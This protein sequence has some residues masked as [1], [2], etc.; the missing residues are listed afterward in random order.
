M[1]PGVCIVGCGLIG[2]K[3]SQALAGARL[4]SCADVLLDRARVIDSV[5][6]A[7]FTQSARASTM[8]G[9]PQA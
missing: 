4:V 8:R 9:D 1:T 5:A 3:R 7:L 6:P 2:R